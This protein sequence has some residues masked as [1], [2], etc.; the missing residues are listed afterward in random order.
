MWTFGRSYELQYYISR[1]VH[2][3][4]RVHAVVILINIIKRL[5]TVELGYGQARLLVGAASS[6]VLQLI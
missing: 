4:K 1:S 6:M 5:G 3:R 2:D